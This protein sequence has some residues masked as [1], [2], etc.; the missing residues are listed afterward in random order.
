MGNSELTETMVSKAK[1]K[2]ALPEGWREVALGEV[3]SIDTRTL[4]SKT[5]DD[6][7]FNYISL[8]DIDRGKLLQTTMLKYS[9]APSR[10]RRMVSKGDVLLATVR[11]NLQGFYIFRKKI[12]NCV[13]STGFAVL[14]PKNYLIDSSYLYQ[15][16]FSHNMLATYNAFNVGSNYPA[17]NSSDIRNFKI[18]I[19]PLPQQKTIASLLEKWD[20]AIEKTEAL[21]AAKEKQFRWLLKTLFG[22]QKNNPEWREVELGDLYDITSSKR[23]FQNE[24]KS[25]G[26]PFYR[27][28]EIVSLSNNGFVDNALF[29]SQEMFN[30]YKKKYGVPNKNDILVTGVGTIGIT[31][32]VKDNREFYFKDGNI[33]WLKYKNLAETAFINYCFSTKYVKQQIL[34]GSAITTVATYTISNAK[35]TKVLLPPLPEQKAIASLLE[36]WDTTIEKTE[37]LA[38]QYR[39][40]K[41]GLMQKLL[42]GEWRMRGN[43]ISNTI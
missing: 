29:I 26:V 37:A 16:L 18:S 1:N 10:A 23:V 40:Q 4:S 11:P 3:C 2:R 14:S 33:I 39:T 9:D 41:R 31:Y 24:W 20:T 42:T 32:H 7:C 35:K 19:P 30:E 38:E 5:R 8:S 6:Y 27:A 12:E 36:K 34:G 13:V 15:M 21:I 43:K 25:A 17:I 22:D 28:R